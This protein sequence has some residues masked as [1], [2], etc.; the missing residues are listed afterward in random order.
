MVLIAQVVWFIG[1]YAMWIDARCNSEL[2]KRGRSMG[3]WRAVLDLAEPLGLQLGDKTCA[4][5]NGEL[6]KKIRR[7]GPV[8][9]YCTEGKD[10]LA[11]LGSS[12]SFEGNGSETSA[13]T[14]KVRLGW[15]RSYGGMVREK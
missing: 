8:R 7:L 2:T 6:G 3:M 15:G 4:Y 1:M 5:G 9:Y 13:G 10:G 14:G 11:H 12:S